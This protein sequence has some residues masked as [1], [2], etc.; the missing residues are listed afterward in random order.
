MQNNRRETFR[1]T[2]R[3][4]RTDGKT[5]TRNARRAVL[6]RVLA[7]NST[8]LGKRF[9][10]LIVLRYAGSR[11]KRS[12]FKCRCDCQ[13]EVIVSGTKLRFGKTASCGSLGCKRGTSHGLS[14]KSRAY[15][16][17][18]TMMARCYNE[19]HERFRDYGGRGIRVCQRWHNFLN[20]LADMGEP[21]NKCVLDR[22]KN[23]R[24]Y[25]PANCRWSTFKQ[26]TQNRSN[27]IWIGNSRVADIAL[28]QGIPPSRIYARWSRGWT[29]AQILRHAGVVRRGFNV[30]GKANNP[31]A[32]CIKKHGQPWN[33][34]P[35]R[36]VQH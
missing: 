17:W 21:P 3:N 29:Y 18:R 12:V 9:G 19:K 24:G 5:R 13:R 7:F 28:L 33:K 23:S 25:S 36:T 31:T 10:R 8:L 30:I 6:R 35:R 26:S 2:S 14:K 4:A 1:R 16:R 32:N 15:N 34:K 27:T 22:M 20:F 11:K